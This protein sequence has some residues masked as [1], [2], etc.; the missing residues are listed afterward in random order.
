MMARPIAAAEMMIALRTCLLA[1]KC[2]P[3]NSSFLPQATGAPPST[4]ADPAPP[5]PGP[6]LSNREPRTQVWL[7]S[8]AEATSMASVKACLARTMIVA[9]SGWRCQGGRAGLGGRRECPSRG[10]LMAARG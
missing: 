3:R 6:A 10:R 9:T 7:D 5:H 2:P 1:I 4:P 8:G